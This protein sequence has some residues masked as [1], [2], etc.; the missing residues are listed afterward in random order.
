MNFFKRIFNKDKKEAFREHI[1]SRNSP[2]ENIPGDELFAMKFVENGGKFLYCTSELEV[3]EVFRNI[4]IELGLYVKIY[5]T[6]DFLKK[7]FEEHESLFTPKIET[8]NVFLTDCEFLIA[9]SGGIMVCSNQLKQKRTDELPDTFIVF[10]KTSQIVKD[11]SEGMQ[12]IKLKYPKRKP[13]GLL[14]LRN[15]KATSHNDI[16]NYGGSYKKTYLILLEDLS[17]EN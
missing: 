7:N 14:T 6:N 12:G 4:L 8:S 11:I 10:T 3:Q 9:S 5:V 16:M 2:D 1:V 17:T 13:T 15:F